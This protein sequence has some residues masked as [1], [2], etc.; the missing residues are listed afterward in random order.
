[1]NR[2][3]IGFGRMGFARSLAVL[4]ALAG[5]AATSGGAGI[6]LCMLTTVV[7]VTI[8]ARVNVNL[9]ELMYRM[10]HSCIFRT[11]SC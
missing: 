4:A 8:A 6:V 11:G 1:M 7:N 3:H 5:A 9:S 10:V 2:D